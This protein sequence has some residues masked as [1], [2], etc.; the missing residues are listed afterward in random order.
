VPEFIELIGRVTEQIEINWQA[1]Q[2]IEFALPFNKW[3]VGIHNHQYITASYAETARQA[4]R[5][6]AVVLQI[7]GRV[8]VTA[9]PD[10]LRRDDESRPGAS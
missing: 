1:Q 7:R 8:C 5:G 6:V 4:S 3:P 9:A 2:F 10:R